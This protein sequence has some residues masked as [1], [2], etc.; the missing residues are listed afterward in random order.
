MSFGLFGENHSIRGISLGGG[1]YAHKFRG[2]Q[3]GL[4]GNVI[5]EECFSEIV[6]A[7]SND[8]AYHSVGLQ[9]AGFFNACAGADG[10]TGMQFAGLFNACAGKGTFNGT[11]AS[12]MLGNV[13]RDMKMNGIQATFI[14]GK[15]KPKFCA[16]SNS[17]P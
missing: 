3:L 4:F 14:F 15:E 17:A 1:F 8:A 5:G 10:F 2:V 7:N 13:C 6:C 12:I 11:Q 9:V 16:D